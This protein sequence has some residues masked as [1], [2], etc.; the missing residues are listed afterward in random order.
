[1]TVQVARDVFGPRSQWGEGWET[2][3]AFLVQCED[4][5]GG[6][7][8][9]RAAAARFSS[10]DE[11]GR[12]LDY[13]EVFQGG[14]YTPNFV[15]DVYVTPRG[16]VVWADTK[17]ELSIP[18]GLKLIKV[19]V[20][21]L[22]ARGVSAAVVRSDVSLSEAT[23]YEFPEDVPAASAAVD[24]RGEAPRAWYLAR[25]V[26][27]QTTDGRGYHDCEFWSASSGW[28][29]D[30]RLAETHDEVPH[31]LVTA[32]RAEPRPS[33]VGEPTAMLLASDADPWPM[34]PP[35]LRG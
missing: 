14:S 4:T 7:A 15:S 1:M 16:L 24:T 10:V 26:R 32:L 12:E 27:R 30:R 29:R 33:E 6:A 22:R 20:E 28:S 19:L 17:G 5:A 11:Q 34:P 13:W 8:A 3:P 2:D 25:S 23:V 31:D 18:M 35:E 21:E 9:L